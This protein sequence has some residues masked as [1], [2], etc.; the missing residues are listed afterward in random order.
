MDTFAAILF[1]RSSSTA[2]APVPVLKPFSAC[3]CALEMPEIVEHVFSLLDHSPL[4]QVSLVCKQWYQLSRRFTIYTTTWDDATTTPEEQPVI[5]E[6]PHLHRVL[7][8][9]FSWPFVHNIVGAP[10]TR[11]ESDER[12]RRML[13]RAPYRKDLGKLALSPGAVEVLGLSCAERS[14][15]HATTTSTAGNTDRVVP[16]SYS[17]KS[18][19]LTGYVHKKRIPS[20]L[21]HVSTSLTQLCVRFETTQTVDL[22]VILQCP[23]L[24]SLDLENCIITSF[25]TQANA[26][27]D[28]ENLSPI[29][30][31]GGGLC[32]K[33]GLSWTRQADES[34]LGGVLTLQNLTLSKT[35]V[36][37][38]SLQCLLRLCADL[39]RFRLRNTLVG[40]QS[41]AY[42]EESLLI[43]CLVRDCPQLAL[44]QLTQ[45]DSP[46]LSQPPLDRLK[47]LP[48]LRGLCLF[49]REFSSSVHRSY[50]PSNSPLHVQLTSLCL[51]GSW[52]VALHPAMDDLVLHQFLC[53]C[54]TLLHLYAYDIFLDVS[55]LVTPP[56]LRG[57]AGRWRET[58]DPMAVDIW[59]CRDLRTLQLS[60]KHNDLDLSH[61]QHQHRVLQYI[62]RACPRLEHL[63]I[64]LFKIDFVAE[65]GLSLLSSVGSGLPALETLGLGTRVMRA[66]KPS[67]VAWLRK[68]KPSMLKSKWL[69]PWNKSQLSRP[70]FVVP[71]P[72][73]PSA[74]VGTDPT[75]PMGYGRE[76]RE[77][78]PRL[79]QLRL[80]YHARDS[81][82]L[83]TIR[84]LEELVSSVRPGV[85]FRVVK[86]HELNLQNW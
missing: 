8:C 70:T 20:I 86:N 72:F 2:A 34:L 71:T 48:C 37:S 3:A 82:T 63:Q 47:N 31:R 12:W 28:P 4:L 77:L 75:E 49:D 30:G 60:F 80:Y 54:P 33:N 59:A 23:R 17:I 14:T 65:S 51:E 11:S 13:D 84:Q 19:Y 55:R 32:T 73:S 21:F 56:P 83:S 76:S 52:R 43:K 57:S 50:L 24:V 53:Q 5:M 79:T 25:G 67:D 42:H 69:W 38:P 6:R 61:L 40:S 58:E 66:A 41:A 74:K 15:S 16:S 64:D 39:R 85:D 46:V 78:W 1:R 45:L 68:K 10:I 35:T 18:L 36:S 26:L 29:E 81:H 22:R 44:L 62:P 27:D 7:R 9:N